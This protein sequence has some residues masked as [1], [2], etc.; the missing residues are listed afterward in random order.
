MWLFRTCIFYQ[1]HNIFHFE[2]MYIILFFPR[3]FKLKYQFAIC[4][5]LQN[6]C[7]PWMVSTTFGKHTKIGWTFI[8]LYCELKANAMRPD[9]KYHDEPCR[10]PFETMRNCTI[11]TTTTR[12]MCWGCTWSSVECFLCAH[13]PRD[14]IALQ[15]CTNCE[16]IFEF[17]CPRIQIQKKDY[18][19]TINTKNM[20]IYDYTWRKC[21]FHA[22]ARHGYVIYILIFKVLFITH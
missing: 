10:M 15:K 18:V 6:N 8:N 19:H 5:F 16:L 20:R 11:C 14:A 7:V 3:T 12:W 17:E 9:A 22:C 13:H 1:T 4:A 2:R 21:H